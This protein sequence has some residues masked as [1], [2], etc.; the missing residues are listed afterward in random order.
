M[1][2]GYGLDGWGSNAGGGWEFYSSSP[3]LADRLWDPPR[4]LSNGYRGLFPLDFHIIYNSLFLFYVCIF[5]AHFSL[6]KT[7]HISVYNTQQNWG[8]SVSVV[9]RPRAERPGFTS[10]RG[11]CWDIFH[12]ATAVS[13]PGLGLT[14][15]PVQ[16]VPEALSPVGEVDHSAWS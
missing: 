14:Q 9:T 6:L 16:W 5:Y 8:S 11:K 15:P 7:P 13:R 10:R 1:A 3:P 12:F 4:L 2:T